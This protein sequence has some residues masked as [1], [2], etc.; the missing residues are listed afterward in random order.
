MDWTLDWTV[1]WTLDGIKALKYK[2]YIR[3]HLSK[4]PK[5]HLTFM[6]MILQPSLC[7][8]ESRTVE[9]QRTNITIIPTKTMIKGITVYMCLAVDSYGH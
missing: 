5:T 6:Q 9:S 2:L 7:I 1:D 3:V 8:N 4:M